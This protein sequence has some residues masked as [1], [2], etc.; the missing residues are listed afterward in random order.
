[1]ALTVVQPD[2]HLAPPVSPVVPGVEPHPVQQASVGS[3]VLED[4]GDLEVGLEVVLVTVSQ[5]AANKPVHLTQLP[6]V[7][8]RVEFACPA[9]LVLSNTNQQGETS[10]AVV[11][12]QG[13]CEA[14]V[15][16]RARNSAGQGG[17]LGQQCPWSD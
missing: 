1:M 2:S 12:E 4:Y 7:V 8:L 6:V 5:L 11:A 16:P 15:H 9:A 3:L 14:L 10:A 13:Q 17:Y